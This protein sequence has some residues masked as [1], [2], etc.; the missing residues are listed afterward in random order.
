MSDINDSYRSNF[1]FGGDGGVGDETPA[2]I[3]IN[4]SEAC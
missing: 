1:S 4:E 2:F 3:S